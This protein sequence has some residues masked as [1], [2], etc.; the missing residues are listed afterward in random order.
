MLNNLNFY[1]SMYFIIVYILYIIYF[2]TYTNIIQINPIYIQIL[3]TINI[4]F[5]SFYL[6]FRFN[7][8]RK[9]KITD[10]DRK[11]IFDSGVFLIFS[12]TFMAILKRY[13]FDETKKYIL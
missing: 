9:N 8:Y 4:Y 3:E 11:I 1:E 5:I 6:V 7:P 10:F 2:I 12:N 13:F